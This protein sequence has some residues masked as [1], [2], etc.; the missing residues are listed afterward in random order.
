MAPWGSPLFCLLTSTSFPQRNMFYRHKAAN[1]YDSSAI[2]L[3]YTFAEIPFV[4]LASSAF[5]LIFYFTMGLAMNAS[6]FFLFWWF[7]T[8]AIATYTYIGQMLVAL[9]KDSQTAQGL[10]SLVISF[11]SLFSGVFIVPS[12]IPPYWIFL[13]WTLPGHWIFEGLF[14]SQFGTDQTMIT[15]SPGTA[16]YASLNCTDSNCQGTI[17]KW[18]AVT[19]ASFS[20]DDI[21]WDIVYLICAIIVTRTVSFVGL[22][23]LNYRAT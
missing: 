22:T 15:A 6:Q 19:F 17:E 11:T 12:E 3:A 13:Y 1:M 14:M 20:V 8:L 9:L 16:F 10:G 5:V 18:M 21:K 2:L 4:I 7:V 23:K